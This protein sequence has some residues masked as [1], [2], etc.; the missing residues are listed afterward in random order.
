[1]GF[2]RHTKDDKKGNYCY[3]FGAGHKIHINT[4]YLL[5]TITCN[6]FNFFH[7][8]IWCNGSVLESGF[9]GTGSIPAILINFFCVFFTAE[10]A[11]G[12]M[13]SE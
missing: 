11:W 6:F 4:K 8:Q 3:F 12:G 1:M 2:S 10:E 5:I 7:L 13:E 9:R